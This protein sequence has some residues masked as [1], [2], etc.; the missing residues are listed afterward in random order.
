MATSCISVTRVDQYLDLFVRSAGTASPA[1]TSDFAP[2]AA[3]GRVSTS[4]S[5]LQKC[6]ISRSRNR[7]LLHEA[8]ARYPPAV[9]NQQLWF[10]DYL[11]V[12]CHSSRNRHVSGQRFF[13][14]LAG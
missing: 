9:F 1:A 12:C 10:A 8:R 3:S 6:G 14:D 4:C 2:I 5:R 7:E 13:E 11:G